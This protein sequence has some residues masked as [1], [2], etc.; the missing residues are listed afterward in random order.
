MAYCP[1]W[2]PPYE[3]EITRYNNGEMWVEGS[4]RAYGT[5]IIMRDS[6]ADLEVD[7]LD[8]KERA[9]LTTW[10]VDERLRTNGHPKIDMNVISEI[11]EAPSLSLDQRAN[12]LLR[13]IDAEL[14]EPGDLYSLNAIEP[15]LLACTESID[16]GG[17]AF[18]VESLVREG[19]LETV[20][21][22]AFRKYGNSRVPKMV[23]IAA[24]GFRRI[25]EAAKRSNSSKVFVAMWFDGEM[26]HAYES[27]ISKAIKDSGY[28]PLKMDE[29]EYIDKIDDQTIS[30]ID[31]SRFL[32]ADFTHGSDGARGSVYYEAGYARG[33]AIP[34]I[35]MCRKDQVDGLHFDVDHFNH[36]TWEDVP[37]LRDALHKRIVDVFGQGPLDSDNE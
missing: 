2:G 9:R 24:E 28:L 1:I 6:G 23:R 11:R 31:D 37:Q 25:E 12:R 17:V 30:E 32:V 7:E 36:L 33:K 14:S 22:P 21:N 8:A 15:R 35:F 16:E 10:L 13:F 29:Q 18:V 27:G 3:V 26:D 19:F 5:Y 34:V 4:D 20:P